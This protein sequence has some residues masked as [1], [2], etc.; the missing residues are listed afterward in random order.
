MTNNDTRINRKLSLETEPMDEPLPVV[1]ASER[2]STTLDGNRES[3]CTHS[4]PER[5]D[6]AHRAG[7]D[8]QKRRSLFEHQPQLTNSSSEKETRPLFVACA[9]RSPDYESSDCCRSVPAHVFPVPR[10]PG[11]IHLPPRSCEH[12][13]TGAHLLIP[14]CAPTEGELS[15]ARNIPHRFS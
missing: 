4:H 6:G 11:K 12:L 9:N 1:D 8:Q 2:C 14:R 5:N 10:S 15:L 7:T 3:D 13:S